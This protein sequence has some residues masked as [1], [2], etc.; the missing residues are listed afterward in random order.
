MNPVYGPHRVWESRYTKSI[1]FFNHFAHLHQRNNIGSLMFSPFCCGRI[2]HRNYST[3]WFSSSV[4]WDNV[5]LESPF[6]GNLVFSVSD[7]ALPILQAPASFFAS[8]RCLWSSIQSSQTQ[9]KI[10]LMDH[11]VKCQGKKEKKNT[12]DLQKNCDLT[13]NNSSGSKRWWVVLWSILITSPTW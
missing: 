7:Q 1:H 3:I 12:I 9:P 6:E 5:I 10:Y 8:I 11:F 4:S 13:V 2:I